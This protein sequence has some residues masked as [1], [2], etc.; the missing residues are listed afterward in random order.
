MVSENGDTTLYQRVS[1]PQLAPRII[2]KSVWNLKQQQQQQ[3]DTL[4]RTGT[5]VAEQNQDTRSSDNKRSTETLVAEEEN[6]F[7]VD[8]RIKGVPQYGVLKDQERMSKIQ[9]LVDNWIPNRV[10]H[11]RFGEEREIQQVQRSIKTF[12]SRIGKY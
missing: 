4:R 6:P 5:P 7:K 8:L 10:D 2:L 9:E 12:N 11:G 1:T 3:Q